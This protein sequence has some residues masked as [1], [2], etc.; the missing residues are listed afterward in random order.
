LTLKLDYRILCLLLVIVIGVMLSL[1]R[2]WEDKPTA[3]TRKITITGEATVKGT[4]DEFV[5]YPDFERTGTD[6]DSMKNELN[7]FGTQLMADLKKLGVPENKIKLDSSSYDRYSY[8]EDK[9]SGSQTIS[10][11]VTITATNKDMAQKVQ[12]YLAKTDAK[13]QLTSYPQFSTET[14]KK[15][16]NQA[17]QKAIADARSKAD[18]SA[19]NLN[20]KLGKVVEVKDSSDYGGITPLMMGAN[21][22]SGVEDKAT[23][24]LPVTPGEDEVDS[25]VSVTF[26]LD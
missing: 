18:E 2:P 3:A 10:L 8:Y 9:P 11:Y 24:S 13:G 7:T 21:S 12:D 20:V 26:A 23:A 15:L 22:A 25:S 14:Q 1:W 17:R 16:E 19:K 4:P 5:F 6:L